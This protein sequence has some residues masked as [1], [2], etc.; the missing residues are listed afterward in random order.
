V[1]PLAL[2]SSRAFDVVYDQ[3]SAAFGR[4][5]ALLCPHYLDV[6]G[7]RC[8]IWQNRNS[9]CSTWFCKHERGAIGLRFWDEMRGLLRAIERTVS[10]WCVF[11]SD[12]DPAALDAV[13]A[14]RSSRLRKLPLTA[15]DLDRLAD[16]EARRTLWGSRAGREKEFY[17]EC[18]RRVEALDWDDVARVGGTDV[19]IAAHLVRSTFSKLIDR[20]IPARLVFGPI[21]IVSVDAENMRTISYSELNP[22][23]LSAELW[24]LLPSF[25][26]RPTSQVRRDLEKNH[27][28][29]LD[30]DLVRKLSDFQ[31]LVPPKPP[32]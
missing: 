3:S 10:A 17:R 31:I 12:L 7:G 21:R 32:E 24:P 13:F 1:T 23:D 6:E 18:A 27:R 19:A 30:D 5:D 22:L 8:G 25:D 2:Y 26:G 11:E 15:G 14:D 29:R 9:V 16:P 20:G 4:A 28:I